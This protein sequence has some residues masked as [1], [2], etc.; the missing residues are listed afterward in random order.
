MKFKVEKQYIRLL[1][2]AK[3]IDGFQ[4][5]IMRKMMFERKTIRGIAAEMGMTQKWVVKKY[6]EG[7]QVLVDFVNTMIKN[8]K[9]IEKTK[10]IKL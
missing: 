5:A 6:D 4:Y 3:L 9:T 1:Y 7:K 2:E 10:I 8:K